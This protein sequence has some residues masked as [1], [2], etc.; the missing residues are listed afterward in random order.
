L[1]K[2]PIQEIALIMLLSL[3]SAPSLQPFVLGYWF[4]KDWAGEYEGHPIE[5][6]PHPGAVLSVNIGRPNATGDGQ[7]APPVSLLGLQTS[8]RKWRSWSETYFVMAM[9]PL[10]A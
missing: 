5:T 6:A 4:V 2:V 3:K 8:A 7:L 1:D 10:W 9:L